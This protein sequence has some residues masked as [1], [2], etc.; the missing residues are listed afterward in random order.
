MN[1][2]ENFCRTIQRLCNTGGGGLP[3]EYQQVEYLESTGEQ[4]INTG[5]SPTEGLQSIIEFTLSSNVVSYS[6]MYIF[7]SRYYGGSLYSSNFWICIPSNTSIKFPR[8]YNDDKDKT[9]TVSAL[10]DNINS[11]L[12]RSNYIELNNIYLSTDVVP[13]NNQRIVPLALFGSRLQNQYGNVTITK[14]PAGLRIYSAKL[15][16]SDDPAL[17]RDYIPCYRKS[18]NIT[19][20]YDLVNKLFTPYTGTANFITGNNVS[21]I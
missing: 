2:C 3:A 16:T 20:M 14:A 4:Y 17:Y 19:G 10:S 1:Y 12:F 9:V 13:I 6:G 15:G 21:W 5:L 8:G 18:D 7:G 11:L